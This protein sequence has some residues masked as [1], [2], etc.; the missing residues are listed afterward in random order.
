MNTFTKKF[1][2]DK[3]EDIE[4][5]KWAELSKK[6]REENKHKNKVN[7]RELF[8]ILYMVSS[9]FKLMETKI[10]Y[11]N[12]TV[13]T[14]YT[15]ISS[16]TKK[17]IN[18]EDI[19]DLM[20]HHHCY[21][22]YKRD[23][24]NKVEFIVLISK[25]LKSITDDN[26]LQK[27]FDACSKELYKKA[28]R[29]NANPL[30]LFFLLAY[31][32]IDRIE[33]KPKEEM[34]ELVRES[35]NIENY[36]NNSDCENDKLEQDC[37]RSNAQNA[38]EFSISELLGCYVD[39]SWKNVKIDAD[40]H[41]IY[42]CKEHIESFCVNLEWLGSGKA[43][44]YHTLMLTFL[45]EFGH[46]AFSYLDYTTPYEGNGKTTHESRANFF[47]SYINKGL[48]DKYI[49]KKVEK[50]PKEYQKPLLCTEKNWEEDPSIK[51]IYSQP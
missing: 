29:E 36:T 15:E 41:N 5:E 10:E 18:L 28:T 34:R 47:V 37:L 2:E 50:Q 22:D 19:I 31:H 14:D 26:D 16:T 40:N 9:D 25:Q 30:D 6:L 33:F 1:I 20:K 23:D 12:I 42:L 38:L 8:H 24:D 13:Y 45:H 39:R 48:E 7:A 35:R 21:I 3:I 46:L 49:Q 17:P 44:Y 11:K 27:Y 43:K 51:E 4:E 32:T